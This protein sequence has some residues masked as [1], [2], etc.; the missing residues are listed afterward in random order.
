VK[1][2]GGGV[3]RHLL[4]T[5]ELD[6]REDGDADLCEDDDENP[7]AGTGSG[8]SGSGGGGTSGGG[9]GSSGSATIAG[10]LVSALVGVDRAA[11]MCAGETDTY[12]AD[13]PYPMEDV[14][15]I[16]DAVLGDAALNG[17]ASC[18]EMRLASSMNACTCGDTA[19]YDNA[20]ATALA[21]CTG[22]TDLE[23]ALEDCNFVTTAAPGP[24]AGASP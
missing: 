1:L 10:E 20:V 15:C 14:T 3:S 21:N 16:R 5:L 13:A 4:R 17:P 7:D 24:D 9:A 22:T 19:C 11:C 18:L 12:C 8:E 6:C 23:T 2:R